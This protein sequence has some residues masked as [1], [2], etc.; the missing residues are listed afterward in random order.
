MKSSELK[1][2]ASQ[3]L[4]KV[5]VLKD[6]KS[7]TYGYPISSQTTGMFL[8]ELADQIKSGQSVIARHPMDF[9][10]FEVGEYDPRTGSIQ[11]MENKNC[12]GL[13][14]DLVVV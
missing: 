11:L 12:L 8:R 5:F 2:D 6:S 4:H 13:V 9:S 7:S 10:I 14:Q 1:N 3:P